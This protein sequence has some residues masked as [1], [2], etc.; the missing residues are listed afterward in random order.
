MSQLRKHQRAR[1]CPHLLCYSCD[2]FI[3]E[4]TRKCVGCGAPGKPCDRPLHSC[5]CCDNKTDVFFIPGFGR[6]HVAQE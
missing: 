4:E 6:T 5:P 3:P 1:S 2:L